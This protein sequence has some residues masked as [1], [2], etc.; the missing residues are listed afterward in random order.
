MIGNRLKL[1]RGGAG[2][3]LRG[4]EERIGRRVTAQAIGKYERNESV[5]SSGVLIALAEGLGVPVEYL[6]SD[7]RLVF[8]GVEFREKTSLRKRDQVRIQALAID[9]LERYLAIEDL[10][11]LPS[12]D[13]DKPHWSPYLVD[14]DLSV[15]EQAA[16]SL[17]TRWHL[18]GNPVGNMVELLEGHGVRVLA[19]D[20]GAI[21]ASTLCA[22]RSGGRVYTL[23]VV[24]CK[25]SGERQ[26]FTLACELGHL[27]LA[28]ETHTDHESDAQR[29]ARAL[30]M[31]P[32]AMRLECG[33][34][35][36]SLG[37]SELLNLKTLFGVSVQTLV[38]R[39][40]DLGI[41]NKALF[42]SLH[43]DMSKLGWRS[44][45]Y[46]EPKP[47]PRERSTR[48]QRLCYRALAEGVVSEAKAAELLSTSI[49]HLR[50]Q[51]ESPQSEF[52]PAPP[53][54]NYPNGCR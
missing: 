24:N 52:M 10:L 38:D 18:G 53:K 16:I 33:A 46:V 30:L 43:R 34:R 35:R 29:F 12:A 40:L 32:S 31:P 8:D 26:R 50:A 22:R 54:E 45:P 28:A 21:R 39:C 9:L 14:G 1:A 44:D 51:V 49:V 20:L 4:L 36:T 2:L 11:A 15:A 27:V 5:P 7:R 3:S 48:F 6:V 41:I 13:W 42:R 23:M 37:W 47:M 19:Y 25:D 17:R